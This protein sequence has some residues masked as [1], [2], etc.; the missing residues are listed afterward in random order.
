MIVAQADPGWDLSDVTRAPLRDPK[1]LVETD[2]QP[3]GFRDFLVALRDQVKTGQQ[4]SDLLRRQVDLI[5]RCIDLEQFADG[6]IVQ[7]VIAL[8]H[9][10]NSSP[11]EFSPLFPIHRMNRIT[12]EIKL[13]PPLIVQHRQHI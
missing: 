5:Q 13:S 8:K 3:D 12:S 9:H 4:V 11:R 2:G 10:S 1:T 7:Q 6:Q